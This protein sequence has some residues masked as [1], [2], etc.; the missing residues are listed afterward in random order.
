[1]RKVV[2]RNAL[3]LIGLSALTLVAVTS[4]RTRQEGDFDAQYALLWGRR[5][6]IYL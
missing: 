6:G 4:T 2:T 3:L 1:M 5:H